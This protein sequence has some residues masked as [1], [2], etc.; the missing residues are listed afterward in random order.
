MFI[1]ISLFKQKL[2]QMHISM[3]NIHMMLVVPVTISIEKSLVK[4]ISDQQYTIYYDTGT[5]TIFFTELSL[6]ITKFNKQ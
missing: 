1:D 5:E 3:H 2:P 6:I 4:T